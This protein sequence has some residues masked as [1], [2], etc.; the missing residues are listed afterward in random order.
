M[1]YRHNIN[2]QYVSAI[3][4]PIIIIII[5]LRY[6]YHTC[7]QGRTWRGTCCLRPGAGRIVVC[8]PPRLSLPAPP[9]LPP[10]PSPPTTPTPTPPSSRLFHRVRPPRQNGTPPLHQHLFR[11]PS[12]LSSSR[13]RRTSAAAVA[14]DAALP[15]L[16]AAPAARSAA[17]E[18]VEQSNGRRGTP[19]VEGTSKVSSPP[20]PIWVAAH[21]QAQ[22]KTT[23]PTATPTTMTTSSPPNQFISHANTHAVTTLSN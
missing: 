10:L 11:D 7:I 3:L 9:P 22:S 16:P 15:A 18:A 2:S 5:I 20:D 1:D 13:Y 6:Y 14:V 12:P 17:A 4:L 8:R 19:R 21:A 23:T